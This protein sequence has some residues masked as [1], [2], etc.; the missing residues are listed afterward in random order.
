MYKHTC[1][2]LLWIFLWHVCQSLSHS[3]WTQEEQLFWININNDLSIFWPGPSECWNPEKMFCLYN[4]LAVLTPA[5]RKLQNYTI[6]LENTSSLEL[7]WWLM[8]ENSEW[9][10]TETWVFPPQWIPWGGGGGGAHSSRVNLALRAG[11]ILSN[12]ERVR[13]DA[14]S[15]SSWVLKTAEILTVDYIVTYRSGRESAHLIHEFKGWRANTTH[16]IPH[17]AVLLLGKA[18]TP[19]CL[20]QQSDNRWRYGSQSS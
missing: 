18:D 6:P 10:Q 17:T 5:A 13:A 20:H 1:F 9:T 8:L 2:G 16:W 14:H 12:P 19:M 4:F 7:C 11:L 15:L 3:M